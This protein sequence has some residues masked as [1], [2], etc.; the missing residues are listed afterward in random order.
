MNTYCQFKFLEFILGSR[1]ADSGST[2]SILVH[3]HG[4]T[5]GDIHDL[6]DTNQRRVYTSFLD[7]GRCFPVSVIC[8]LAHRRRRYCLWY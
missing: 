8:L 6:R 2:S 1:P 7:T 4:R 3:R 5:D